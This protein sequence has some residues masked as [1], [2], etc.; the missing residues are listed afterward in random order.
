MTIR[1]MDEGDKLD[2]LDDTIADGLAEVLHGGAGAA[3]EDE[4]DGLVLLGADLLLDVGLVLL[5]ELG[6]ELDVAGLWIL[7]SKEALP[8]SAYP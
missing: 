4:E 1:G 7:V 5:Q 2:L 6:A 8:T 3:M